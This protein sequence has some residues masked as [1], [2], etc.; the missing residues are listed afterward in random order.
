MDLQVT[1]DI[2]DN[3]EDAAR[4][5]IARR[6]GIV[7]SFPR[8]RGKPSNRGGDCNAAAAPEGAAKASA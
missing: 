5:Y 1:L 4:M 3:T 8:P 2:M 6:G 7:I